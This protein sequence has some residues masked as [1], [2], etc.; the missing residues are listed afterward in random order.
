MAG[1]GSSPTL[2]VILDLLGLDAAT[3]QADP[4]HSAS[5]IWQETNCAADLWIE[6]LHA[7]GFNPVVALGF[8]LSGDFDGSQ[9]RM[10]KFAPEDLRRLFGVEFDELNV[11]R[12]LVTQVAE[13]LA[14]G[15]P[16]TIDVDAWY[17]PDTAGLTYR[18]GHQK[19]TILAV[20]IDED[21]RQLGYLHNTGYYE[22][23][24]D[25]F[26]A[27]FAQD[28]TLPPYV[29]SVR[30]DNAISP[31]TVSTALGVEIGLDHFK[32]RPTT[33]PVS[34][35]RKR[36]EEDLGDLASEGLEY[37]HRYAFGTIRQCGANAELAASFVGWLAENDGRGGREEA[38]ESFL[39]LAN[40]MKSVEFVLARAARG[41]RADVAGSFHELED[42]WDSAMA[43]VARR[44]DR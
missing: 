42:C 1:N 44:Y 24:D 17:L 36:I 12:P 16:T 25:D 4:L 15:R 8:T 10:F 34:R 7:I 11:W 19:T 29:E 38:A 40:G 31:E 14:L 26:E 5:R 21:A 2:A 23:T 37:F 43:A 9:W 6:A 27:L 20:K 22:L 32:R 30:L 35:M 41:R 13:Q 39:K 18:C 33:N 3:Y 28:G